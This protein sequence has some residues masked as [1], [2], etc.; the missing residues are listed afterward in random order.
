MLDALA[1]GINTKEG[2]ISRVWKVNKGSS[3][4]Y[5]EA[6]VE[7]EQVMHIISSIGRRGMNIYQAG[8][9]EI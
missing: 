3:K 1:E 7:Y 2:I 6:G 4:E 9:Q 8:E 5:K